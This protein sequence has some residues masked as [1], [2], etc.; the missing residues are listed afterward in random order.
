MDCPRCGGMMILDHF[1]DLENTGQIDFQGS[2]CLICGEI[3]DPIIL[4]NRMHSE[5]AL[6]H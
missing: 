3:L 6:V 4:V 5:S 2:R 1:L